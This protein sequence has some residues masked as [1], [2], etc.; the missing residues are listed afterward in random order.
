MAAII[1]RET[2]MPTIT[3]FTSTVMVKHRRQFER[4][5]LVNVFWSR[6]GIAWAKAV[7]HTWPFLTLPSLMKAAWGEEFLS[8]VAVPLMLSTMS[9]NHLS[10]VILHK[11]RWYDTLPGP[12]R[13]HFK[14]H[15]DFFFAIGLHG[16]VRVRV[17]QHRLTSYKKNGENGENDKNGENASVL[18]D[19]WA[20]GIT[21]FQIEHLPSQT[22]YAHTLSFRVTRLRTPRSGYTLLRLIQDSEAR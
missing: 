1:I 5:L 4:C 19:E 18:T 22:R 3:N 14:A 17:T 9:S 13:F 11:L 7:C 12:Y 20:Q 6:V 10:N 21:F 16:A 2:C 8:N 15:Q